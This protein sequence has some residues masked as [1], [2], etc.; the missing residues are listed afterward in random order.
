MFV[1]LFRYFEGKASFQTMAQN[2]LEPLQSCASIVVATA[3]EGSGLPV[4]VHRTRARDPRVSEE[5]P[6]GWGVLGPRHFVTALPQ[7]HVTCSL[8]TL[9]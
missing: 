2:A 6:C 5:A 9:L 8:R 4:P 3:R 1:I 7:L